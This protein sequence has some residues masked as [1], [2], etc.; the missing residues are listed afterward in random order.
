MTDNGY[1]QMTDISILRGPAAYGN[2]GL[3]TKTKNNW[4]AW[5]YLWLA[6]AA[7]RIISRKCEAREVKEGSMSNE[8]AK[9]FW[10]E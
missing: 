1:R 2:R 7:L 4:K 5:K 6:A 8:D 10:L 9:E 3:K